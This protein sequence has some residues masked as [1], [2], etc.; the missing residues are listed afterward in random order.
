MSAV[1]RLIK[2]PTWWWPCNVETCC[3]SDTYK[4][5]QRCT[6]TA[7]SRLCTE[8]NSLATAT[9]LWNVIFFSLSQWPR[10]LRHELSPPAQTLG[11][12]VPI[13][14]DVWTPVCV[15]SVCVVLCAG[16]GLLMGWSPVKGVV[17]TVYRIKEL[18][19]RPTPNKWAVEPLIIIIIIRATHISLPSWFILRNQW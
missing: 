19:K 8:M 3:R 14:L 16:R 15:Y 17:S 11:S 12:W 2:V 13:P 18:K 6:G 10:G 1:K 7:P 5:W 4:K 9:G